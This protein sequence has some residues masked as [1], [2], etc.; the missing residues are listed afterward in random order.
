MK[1]QSNLFP[2]VDAI[3]KLLLGQHYQPTIAMQLYYSLTDTE[4]DKAE[5]TDRFTYA[6]IDLLEELE[7]IYIN[8]YAFDVY[9]VLEINNHF[10]D[11]S[12][13]CNEDD[14]EDAEDSVL[15]SLLDSQVKKHNKRMLLIDTSGTELI[16]LPLPIKDAQALQVLCLQFDFFKVSDYIDDTR[17]IFKNPFEVLPVLFKKNTGK[18]PVLFKDRKISFDLFHR[19]LETPLLGNQNFLSTWNTLEESLEI[20]KEEGENQSLLHKL[21]HRK[22]V[23]NY[24]IFIK[25]KVAELSLNWTSKTPDEL[26]VFYSAVQKDTNGHVHTIEQPYFLTRGRAE[27]EVIPEKHPLYSLWNRTLTGLENLEYYKPQID[28]TKLWEL[29]NMPSFQATDYETIHQHPS[30]PIQYHIRHVAHSNYKKEVFPVLAINVGSD[31]F[32]YRA[33]EKGYQVFFSPNNE[34]FE[35]IL[36]QQTVRYFW[37]VTLF[38]EIYTL[39]KSELIVKTPHL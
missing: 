15:F 39:I 11:A 25:S 38:T 2:I 19:V 6:V 30:K 7:L 18:T 24:A 28:Y 10:L 32:Y 23:K 27:T 4:T 35:L 33:F 13:S 34:D 16:F 3:S 29:V 14:Y 20:L 5:K 21:T 1:P 26:L 22:P 37:A 8:D 31:Y 36:T 12:I 9:D 17:V